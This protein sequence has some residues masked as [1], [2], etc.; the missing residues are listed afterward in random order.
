MVAAPQQRVKKG[1]RRRRA[2]SH[3]IPLVMLKCVSEKRRSELAGRLP[4]S[5]RLANPP[6][7]RLPVR[8]VFRPGP[9]N[10]RCLEASPAS[11]RE[12][13]A[14]R[15]QA[16]ARLFQ[17]T[18]PGIRKW[19]RRDPQARFARAHRTLARP[20]SP[21]RIGRLSRIYNVTE[22]AQ[23]EPDSLPYMPDP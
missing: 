14:A 7:I 22:R 5:G 12:R 17:T 9:G 20:A 6:T 1:C 23:P 13:A 11:G 4:K 2:Y 18:A 19:L 16:T 21:D 10:E 15:H 3:R 8:S